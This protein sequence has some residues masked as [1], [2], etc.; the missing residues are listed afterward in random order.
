MAGERVQH[1]AG[2]TGGEPRAEGAGGARGTESAGSAGGAGELLPAHVYARDRNW[3][4][5]FDTMANLP[6]RPTLM[7]AL[8][9]FELEEQASGKAAGLTGR[10]A[11]S[12]DAAVQRRAIDL[13]CGEGRDT[14][15]LLRRGWSVV[16]IDGSRDGLDRVEKRVRAGC[17]ERALTRLELVLRSFEEIGAIGLPGASLVNASFALPFCPP[18]AFAG[19]WGRIV[20]CLEPGGRF[21]GQF[22]G[23][24]DAW[25]GLPDRT[26]HTRAE[27]L[28][29]LAAGFEVESL[30]EDERGPTP[31]ATIGKCWHVFHV[32]AKRR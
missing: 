10:Q 6:A 9:R 14:A 19:L 24:R 28:A 23:D 8:E 20:E 30:E 21:A 25:A 18:R 27:V 31:G 3:P 2:E 13:G 32:V 29:L 7:K 5:Y 15:E 22:F 11:I 4:K 1:G 17:D 12:A 16:A 26:H